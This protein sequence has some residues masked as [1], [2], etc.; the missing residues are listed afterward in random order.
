MSY[1]I[2]EIE[3]IGPTYREKLTAAGV[4]TTDHLLE[5][6]CS[7]DGRKKMAAQT[8]LSEKQLLDWTNMADL[9]RVS[10]VGR[11]YAE[12]LEAAGVDTIKELRTRNAENLAAKIVE[13]NTEKKL[14]NATPSVSVVTD[15]I[16]QANETEPKITH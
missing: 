16:A 6:C 13:V 15:W 8:G 10:G 14:A 5:H 12:L 2:D 1:K 7:K 11:Q 9:M 3:G 4:T